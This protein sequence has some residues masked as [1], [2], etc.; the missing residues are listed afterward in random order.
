MSSSADGWVLLTTCLRSTPAAG[1]AGPGIYAEGPC[2]LATA[3]ASSIVTLHNVKTGRGCCVQAVAGCLRGDKAFL[4]AMDQH[5]QPPV[6]MKGRGPTAAA[7][8]QNTSLHLF[9]IDLGSL[10]MPSAPPVTPINLFRLE[11]QTQSPSPS[12]SSSSG[13]GSCGGGGEGEDGSEQQQSGSNS[14][15]CAI[16]WR[17]P[18]PVPGLAALS[19][20]PSPSSAGGLCCAVSDYV[21]FV[22]PDGHLTVCDYHNGRQLATGALLTDLDGGSGNMGVGGRGG[23]EVSSSLLQAACLDL[24]TNPQAPALSLLVLHSHASSSISGTGSR[25]S[26]TPKLCR[27]ELGPIVSKIRQTPSGH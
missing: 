20:A 24:V 7:A 1:P 16:V 27:V 17:V 18:V 15:S 25:P 22:G 23:G 26:V 14:N 8:A 13:S 3:L 12:S 5:P 21:F 4:V 2:N 6:D 19:L 11:T 10:G 9:C